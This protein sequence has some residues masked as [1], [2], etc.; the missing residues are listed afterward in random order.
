[1]D[2]KKTMIFGQEELD[3]IN[4]IARALQI[5]IKD[6]LKMTLQKGFKQYDPEFIE[7]AKEIGEKIRNSKTKPYFK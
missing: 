2:V 4:G 5:Q 3:I 1:M 7:K 6:S